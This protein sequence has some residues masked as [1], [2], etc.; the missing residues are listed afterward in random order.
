M[1]SARSIRPESVAAM[2]TID[3]RDVVTAV[4]LGGYTFSALVREVRANTLATLICDPA[5][6]RLSISELSERAGY[7]DP[8]QASVAFSARFGVT[9]T[10][11]RKLLSLIGEPAS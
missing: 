3:T 10:N 7:G 2:L 9:M 11:Y 1:I 4:R 8:Q 5:T 6:P